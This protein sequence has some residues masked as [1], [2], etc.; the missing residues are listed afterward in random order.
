VLTTRTGHAIFLALVILEPM[1]V[2][3][4][5]SAI[6]LRRRWRG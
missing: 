5:G 3:A 1:L 2:F 4:I 6:A